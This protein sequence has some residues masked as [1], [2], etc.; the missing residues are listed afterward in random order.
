MEI[1]VGIG[2]GI[3]LISMLHACRE[4]KSVQ[5]AN[6]QSIADSLVYF[7]EMLK[8]DSLQDSIYY[9]RGIWFIRKNQLNKGIEDLKKA[10]QL[11]PDKPEYV[12]SLSDAYLLNIESRKSI[13]V[14]DSLL[15]RKPDD[16]PTLQ[17][18]ARLHLI[19][20]DYNASLAVIDRILEHDRE[21]SQAYYLAG[22]VFYEQGDT[23]RAVKS[24][25]KAV[26]INPEFTE[27]WN[28]LGDI[29]SQLNNPLAIKFYDN[30]LR[31]DSLNIETLHN[32]AY[33]LQK[34]GRVKEAIDAYQTNIGK[35]PD[36][37]LSY[38]NLGILL[39]E[40]NQPEK[41]LENINQAILL[42][43][44]EPSSYYYR[45]KIF[46]EKGNKDLAKKDLQAAIALYPD[47]EKAKQLLKG[48]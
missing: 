44:K 22:H 43:S 46:I 1:R 14:I 48:L 11:R 36:F 40:S 25:Q 8:A 28:Q 18:K 27:A 20:Q 4:H 34:E 7:D 35:R 17:K 29:M 21:N 19:I 23:G 9:S 30:A 26:D 37:E 38:Y 42:N 3:V 12:F 2:F 39:Y 24:Y 5:T 15:L 10:V 41:A 13:D 16:I 33:A 45:A 31:M 47:Y 32:R 6:S